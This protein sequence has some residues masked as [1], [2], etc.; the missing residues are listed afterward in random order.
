MSVWKSGSGRWEQTL[1]VLASLLAAARFLLTQ[2]FPNYGE[3]PVVQ[4]WL[5]NH[6]Q[7]PLVAQDPV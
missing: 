2:A 7:N 6:D 5:M 4:H 3:W 1:R